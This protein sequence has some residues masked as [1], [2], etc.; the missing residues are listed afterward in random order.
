MKEN[1]F[2][3]VLTFTQIYEKLANDEEIKCFKATPPQPFVQPG[4]I[5]FWYGDYIY[6]FYFSSF[7][8]IDTMKIQSL[9]EALAEAEN[10]EEET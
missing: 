10:L 1:Y 8:Y 6:I 2:Y 7:G 9:D 5:G 3:R 4:F